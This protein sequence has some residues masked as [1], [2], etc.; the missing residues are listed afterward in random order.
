MAFSYLYWWWR[1]FKFV[2]RGLNS[3]MLRVGWFISSS[4]VVRRFAHFLEQSKVTDLLSPWVSAIWFVCLQWPWPVVH[5]LP[6]IHSPWLRII[7]ACFWGCWK[8][9]SNPFGAFGTK[10]KHH[11]ALDRSFISMVP[12]YCKP[13]E[14]CWDITPWKCSED[15]RSKRLPCRFR[16]SQSR[17]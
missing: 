15:V 9:R 5:D 14:N 4:L 6:C 7:L 8:G 17:D 3:F 11:K 2:L 12:P 13:F 1:H 10:R 16:W